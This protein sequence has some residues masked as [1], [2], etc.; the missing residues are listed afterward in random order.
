MLIVKLNYCK[1]KPV[2]FNDAFGLEIFHKICTK[3][4]AY[5]NNDVCYDIT[6]RQVDKFKLPMQNLTVI[7]ELKCTHL[8]SVKEYVCK[9]C[10]TPRLLIG[11]DNYFLIA[12]LQVLHGNKNEPYATKSRLGWSIHGCLGRTAHAFYLSRAEDDEQVSNDRYRL[13]KR[14]N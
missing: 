11:E 9:D 8:L 13:S 10:V 7:N 1:I 2:K 14:F 3:I 5:D 6:L 12:P 4:S